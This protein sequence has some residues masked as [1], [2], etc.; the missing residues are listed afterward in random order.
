M[1]GFGNLGVD[2]MIMRMFLVKYILKVET[3]SRQT[4]VTDLYEDDYGSWGSKTFN[5]C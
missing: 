3:S 2:R 5:F 1:F 4:P